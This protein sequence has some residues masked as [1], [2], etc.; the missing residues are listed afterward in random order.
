MPVEPNPPAPPV[1]L[2]EFFLLV[3]GKSGDGRDN[4]LGNPHAAFHVE[5][6]LAVIDQDGANLAP[7][8]R[9]N[10]PRA[11]DQRYPIFRCETGTGSDLAS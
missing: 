11:V 1:R 6:F 5:G 9:I 7:V 8:V 3:P 2:A 4:H 10:G